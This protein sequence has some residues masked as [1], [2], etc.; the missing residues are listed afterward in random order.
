MIIKFEGLSRE[1]ATA[2]F[3]NGVG[4][5]SCE[6]KVNEVPLVVYLTKHQTYHDS[7]F[8][9]CGGIRYNL[10]FQT[11]IRVIIKTEAELA[12]E[13]SVQD[14]RKA[15]ESAEKALIKVKEGAK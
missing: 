4:S 12:A 6:L 15:L 13:K 11:Y 3:P 9:A 7:T 5:N 8:Q 14:A 2:I 10:T 1:E